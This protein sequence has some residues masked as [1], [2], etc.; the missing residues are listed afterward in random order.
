MASPDDP[1]AWVAHFRSLAASDALR[2]EL[3]ARGRAQ[4]ERF[5]WTATA[6]GYLDLMAG[7]WD[8]TPGSLHGAA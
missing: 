8:G 1:A 3:R 5:S 2:G 7:T 6:Q 4:A